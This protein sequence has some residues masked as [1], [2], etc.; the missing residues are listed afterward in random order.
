[1]YG[2]GRVTV[3]APNVPALIKKAPPQAR[4]RLRRGAWPTNKG[5]GSIELGPSDVNVATGAVPVGSI[6]DSGQDRSVRQWAN[7][8]G[9]DLNTGPYRGGAGGALGAV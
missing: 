2:H 9:A 4:V 7:C 6:C 1:M 3:G 5:W 8:T